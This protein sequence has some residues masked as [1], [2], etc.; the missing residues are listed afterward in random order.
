MGGRAVVN[1]KFIGA[2][3]ELEVWCLLIGW[4]V[5]VS[6]WL[7]CDDLSLAGLWLSLFG[8]IVAGGGG[9]LPSSG[10]SC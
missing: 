4:A 2:N 1:R 5:A 8:W 7:S 6:H 9:N 10:S 3:S